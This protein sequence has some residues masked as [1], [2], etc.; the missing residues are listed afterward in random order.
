MMMER[1]AA[2]RSEL[3][4]FFDVL[5]ATTVPHADGGRLINGIA[6][7]VA[8]EKA[9]CLLANQVHESHNLLVKLHGVECGPVQGVVLRQADSPNGPWTKVPIECVQVKSMPIAEDAFMLAALNNVECVVGFPLDKWNRLQSSRPGSNHQRW[10]ANDV[11]TAEQLEKLKSAVELLRLAAE[12]RSVKEHGRDSK[13]WESQS[14]QKR[15]WTQPDLDEAIREYKAKMFS[16]YNDLVNGVKCGRPG[17]E[18]SARETFGRNAIARKLEVRSPT[19]VGNSTV[20][21]AIADQLGLHRS[22][23]AKKKRIGIE[24]AL[25]KQGVASSKS[26]VDQAIQ[27]E[28][29]AM[30]NNGMPEKEAEATI[31]KLLGDEITDD[32]AREL[33]DVCADQKQDERTRNVRQNL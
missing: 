31:E 1:F 2:L 9:Q 22:K 23:P 11:V 26:A 20:W 27:R 5:N 6:Q 29:V 10:R 7:A 32:E 14:A 17:A 33:I 21:Q 12:N 25:E 8:L 28:T 15:S 30:V 18:K 4:Y 24:F 3:N 19:M 13:Q 16:T